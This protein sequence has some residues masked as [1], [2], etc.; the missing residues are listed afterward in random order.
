MRLGIRHTKNVKH[1]QGH[2][3]GEW[4]YLVV[5]V[6]ITDRNRYNIMTKHSPVGKNTYHWL[7]L[8]KILFEEGDGF[9][10]R[11]LYCTHLS[12]RKR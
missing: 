5:N 1:K 8:T 2:V 12:S 6:R 10:F 7:I 11:M 3:M 9:V 4:D